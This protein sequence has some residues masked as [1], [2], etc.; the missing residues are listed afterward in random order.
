MLKNI[1]RIQHKYLPIP[2]FIYKYLFK[3]KLFLKLSL[4]YGKLCYDTD[5]KTYGGSSRSLQNYWN[6]KRSL[7]WHY[8]WLHFNR[9]DK[10]F[11]EIYKKYPKI[12]KD[13][14]VCDLMTGIGAPYLLSEF[15]N[16]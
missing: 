13:L 10:L 14:R 16:K 9:F 4:K 12:F 15:K 6:S 8:M 2:L 1:L 11:L 5:F 3:Y 7:Y